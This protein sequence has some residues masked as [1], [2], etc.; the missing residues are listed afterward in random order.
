[1]SC[2]SSDDA[3]YHGETFAAIAQSYNFSQ[4]PDRVVIAR[5]ELGVTWLDADEFIAAVE[6]ITALAEKYLFE[7]AAIKLENI[8]DVVTRGSVLSIMHSPT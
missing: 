6:R 1:M 5:R 4:N 7:K 3:R 8:S 2:S